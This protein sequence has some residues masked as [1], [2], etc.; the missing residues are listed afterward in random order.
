M[1][2]FGPT[3]S[4][5]EQYVRHLAGMQEG[6]SPIDSEMKSAA[7]AVNRSVLSTAVNAVW[8]GVSATLS[9][10]L[11]GSL[12]YPLASIK[13]RVTIL[14]ADPAKVCDVV[15]K[16]AH[17]LKD[18]FVHLSGKF[19]GFVEELANFADSWGIPKAS[20]EN[21]FS[22]D[23]SSNRVLRSIGTE[24]EMA[25]DCLATNVRGAERSVNYAASINEMVQ[26]AW[27][28]PNT[29]YAVGF[30][31]AGTAL[32]AFIDHSNRASKLE[33]QLPE[34]LSERY[35]QI[36][37]TIQAM[38]SEAES[39]GL[40]EDADA[41][42]ELAEGIVNNKDETYAEIE[43]LQLPNMNRGERLKL[44]QPIIELANEI[45]AAQTN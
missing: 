26:W 4:Q 6:A 17:R 27:N 23:S 15:G 36:L 5:N 35:A 24:A 9:S 43:A 25:Q 42:R 18:D 30:A 33:M 37:D 19:T 10:G 21:L 31:V 34:A 39:S 40:L 44:V 7:Q 29:P 45:L 28:H 38:K 2:I 11:L 8:N 3:I 14:G 13:E 41:F 32:V 12:L 16:N 20:V 1:S 22:S